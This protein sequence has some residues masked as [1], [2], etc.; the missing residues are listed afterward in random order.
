MN[1]SGN[2]G[3]TAG[4]SSLDKG[5]RIAGPAEEAL[6]T[7]GFRNNAAAKLQGWE[8]FAGNRNDTGAWNE[9]DERQRLRTW[10]DETAQHARV[11]VLHAKTNVAETFLR[12]SEV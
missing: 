12:L 10:P 5:C 7:H 4:K 2:C 8:A 3:W 1:L 11:Q 6:S 9:S